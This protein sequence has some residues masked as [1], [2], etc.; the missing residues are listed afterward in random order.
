MRYLLGWRLPTARGHHVF[1]FHLANVQALHGFAEFFVGFED[2]FWI[3][4]VRGGLD[5]RFGTGF[6]IAGLENSGADEDSF[7][8]EAADER[9]VGGRGNSAG[10]EIGNRKLAGLGDLTD[11]FERGAKFFGFAHQFVFA[12]GGEFFHL[13][14]DGAHVAD[15][16]DNIAGAGFAFGANHG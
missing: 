14:D 9:G 13:A 4:E 1:F 6:G 15:G 12:H 11:E 8:A 16:F 2:D 10:G 5:D 7:G 3:F